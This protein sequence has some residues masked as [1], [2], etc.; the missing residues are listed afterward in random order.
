MDHARVHCL[1]GRSPVTQG[2]MNAS[3]GNTFRIVIGTFS[4]LRLEK[5][6]TESLKSFSS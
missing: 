5:V 1:C 6:G 4:S 2:G 3:L